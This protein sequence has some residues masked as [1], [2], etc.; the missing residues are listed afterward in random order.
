M[1]PD[2]NEDI[3][4]ERSW[5]IQQILAKEDRLHDTS[6]DADVKLSVFLKDLWKWIALPVLDDLGYNSAPQEASGWPHVW[7]ISTGVLCLYPIHAAGVGLHSKKNN[8]MNRVI[9]SYTPTHLHY[10]HLLKHGL[11][12]H[13]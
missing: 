13:G 11:N 2:A 7:W 6:Y 12:M 3:L 8:V 4:S 1:L 5:E 9:S 10:E